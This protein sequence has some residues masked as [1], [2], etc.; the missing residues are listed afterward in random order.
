MVITVRDCHQHRLGTD[1]LK[2]TLQICI[3]KIVLFVMLAQEINRLHNLRLSR[4]VRPERGR[5]I[6]EWISI[7]RMIC[8]TAGDS[9]LQHITTVSGC[10]QPGQRPRTDSSVPV[11]YSGWDYCL[12]GRT[13]RFN[14]SHILAIVRRSDFL[15]RCS[16]R[17]TFLTGDKKKACA[18]VF[19][20][21]HS[22]ISCK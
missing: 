14:R 20:T 8:H 19:D 7:V 13:R 18:R 15:W 1:N 10:A 11:S 3:T 9:P 6:I 22:T 21:S 16:N 2:E 5:S 4:K 12:V 17:G